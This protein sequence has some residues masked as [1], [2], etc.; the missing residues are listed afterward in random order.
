MKYVAAIEKRGNGKCMYCD[1]ED[2]S[3]HTYFHCHKWDDEINNLQEKIHTKLRVENLVDK[4]PGSE[5]NC[6]MVE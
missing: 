5:E 3:E 1:S 2:D 6:K 4:M